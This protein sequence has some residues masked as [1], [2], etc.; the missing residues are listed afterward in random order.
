[1]L[2][3]SNTPG[4]GRA[5]DS[6]RALLL[7]LANAQD[8]ARLVKRWATRFSDWPDVESLHYAQQWLRLAWRHEQVNDVRGAIATFV[9]NANRTEHAIEYSAPRNSAAV[10]T[11]RL[12]PRLFN[13][14]VALGVARHYARMAVCV[15]PECP[16]RYFLGKLGQRACERGPCAEYAQ[17][18]YKREWWSAHGTDRRKAQSRRKR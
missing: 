14:A 11:V 17:R 9:T 3:P 8:S 10:G 2:H 18:L 7:D 16:A 1:M 15:N 6:S 4:A 13:L 5:A 12:N